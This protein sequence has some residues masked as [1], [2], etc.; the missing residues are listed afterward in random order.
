M[1]ALFRAVGA[2]YLDHF[3]LAFLHGLW[4]DFRDP[5]WE[6]KVGSL[7]SVT[8]ARKIIFTKHSLDMKGIKGTE[9]YVFSEA[10]GRFCRADFPET[11]ESWEQTVLEDQF[12]KKIN[13][14]KETN[15]PRISPKFERDEAFTVGYSSAS[16][17]IRLKKLPTR[18]DQRLK[19]YQIKAVNLEGCLLS[20][21]AKCGRKNNISLVLVI[22]DSCDVHGSLV[23]ELRDAIKSIITSFVQAVVVAGLPEG[24]YIPLLV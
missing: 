1:A 8:E 24:E 11:F 10:Q 7:Y 21:L 20:N 3:T 5:E 14:K 17:K 16:K 18:A 9:A 13:S 2:H 6:L 19:K 4:L 22:E 23:P 15:Q 12:V